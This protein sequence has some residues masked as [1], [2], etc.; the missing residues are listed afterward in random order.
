MLREA[1]GGL[2]AT[3][4]KSKTWL[5]LCPH[6]FLLFSVSFSQI[7]VFPG[8]LCLKACQDIVGLSQAEIWRTY[9]NL[10]NSHCYSFMKTNL[11]IIKAYQNTWGFVGNSYLAHYATSLYHWSRLGLTKHLRDCWQELFGL[12]RNIA[13][14]LKSSRPDKTEIK[15][16]AEKMLD[17]CLHPDSNFQLT[18]PCVHCSNA[19]PTK[20]PPLLRKCLWNFVNYRKQIKYCGNSIEIFPFWFLMIMM[21]CSFKS[22]HEINFTGSSTFKKIIKLLLERLYNI[23]SLIL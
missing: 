17:K 11:T 13:M 8:R 4:D 6:S 7:L 19:L 16:I 21:S 5:S 1:R 10:F 14:S 3:V 12:L 18:P 22:Q 20:L 23:L 9:L 15:I 2:K